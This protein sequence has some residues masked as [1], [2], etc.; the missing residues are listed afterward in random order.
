M[1]KTAIVIRC[2]YNNRGWRGACFRPRK[3]PECE[4]CFDP[5]VEIDPPEPDDEECSGNCWER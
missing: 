3:D 4:P 5:V 1:D 2:M